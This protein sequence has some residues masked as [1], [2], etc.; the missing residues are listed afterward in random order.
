MSPPYMDR[1]RLLVE[2][3]FSAESADIGLWVVYL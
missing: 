1:S 3:S 2:S